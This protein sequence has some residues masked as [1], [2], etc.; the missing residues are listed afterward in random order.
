MS[1][2]QPPKSNRAEYFKKPHRAEY[3]KKH[4]LTDTAQPQPQH[5]ADNKKTFHN[6]EIFKYNKGTY[7]QFIYK[8]ID[9]NGC[10]QLIEPSKVNT[11]FTVEY[12]DKDTETETAETTDNKKK[13]KKCI[14]QLNTISNLKF[15]KEEYTEA[16]KNIKHVIFEY[17]IKFP[18]G[19]VRQCNNHYYINM[20]DT[21]KIKIAQDKAGYKE[22]DI[23]N[24]KILLNNIY[25]DNW[26]VWDDFLAYQFNHI[27][28]YQL[29]ECITGLSNCGKT[30]YFTI[31]SEVFG[32]TNCSKSKGLQ[33]DFIF[34]S[35]FANKR[36]TLMDEFKTDNKEL[37]NYIKDIIT[38]E[39]IEYER[40][41]QDK[42]TIPYFSNIAITSEEIPTLLASE[43][44]NKRMVFRTVNK[45]LP[46]D[47]KDNILKE[48]NAIRYYY[49]HHKAKDTKPNTQ[50]LIKLFSMVDSIKADDINTVSRDAVIEYARELTHKDTNATHLFINLNKGVLNTLEDKLRESLGK[51]ILQDTNPFN[52]FE[53]LKEW[54]YKQVGIDYYNS[55]LNNFTNKAYKKC[56]K[57]ELGLLSEVL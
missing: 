48:I 42:Q 52:N 19:N 35:S 1:R 14:N 39:Y 43:L 18:Y 47:F 55:N 24:W 2:K 7:I 32:I 10:I 21:N 53:N 13:S 17:E 26:Q 50:E 46:T 3:L 23:S 45:V 28:N 41:G 40:K 38:S 11:M 22:G 16:L 34:N 5:T 57:I 20:F 37:I 9:N 8:Y 54:C 25:G 44:K 33:R 6:L 30:L 4:G 15:T 27:E 31:K 29:G 49:K 51:T 12:K 56:L 36:Q